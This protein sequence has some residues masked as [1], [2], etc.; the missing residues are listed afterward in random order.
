MSRALGD[1]L[2]QPHGV[3]AE[4]DVALLPRSGGE[5]FLLLAT[6]GLWGAVSNEVGRSRGGR[7][8]GAAGHSMVEGGCCHGLVDHM[9]ADLHLLHV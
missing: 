8:C 7:G 4:P 5:D 2:L 6:D 9:C 1:H 3:S